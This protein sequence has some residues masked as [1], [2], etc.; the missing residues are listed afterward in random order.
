MATAAK[1][2]N[3]KGTAIG[4]LVGGVVGAVFGS[5]SAGGQLGGVAGNLL[6]GVFSKKVKPKPVPW[7]EAHAGLLLVGAVAV[8]TVL[9]IAAKR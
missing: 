7:W 8:G 1:V 5:G 9:Y 6:S 2:T 4:S 3:P